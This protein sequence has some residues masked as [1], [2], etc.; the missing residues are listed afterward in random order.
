MSLT[1]P[2]PPEESERTIL[3][4]SSHR[5]VVISVRGRPLPR[6]PYFESSPLLHHEPASEYAMFD[7]VHCSW[8]MLHAI[9]NNH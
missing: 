4:C 3:G 7:C 8:V 9:D 6:I 1:W 5:N 2:T